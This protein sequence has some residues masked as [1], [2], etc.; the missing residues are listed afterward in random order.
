MESE[1]RKTHGTPRRWVEYETGGANLL[2]DQVRDVSNFQFV[3]LRWRRTRGWYIS[4]VS[5]RVIEHVRNGVQDV[6][7]DGLVGS[8]WWSDATNLGMKHISPLIRTGC[9]DPPALDSRNLSR[10]DNGIAEDFTTTR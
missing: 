8:C 2:V 9:H 6:E 10:L 4:P 3:H 1:A 7:I 5:H